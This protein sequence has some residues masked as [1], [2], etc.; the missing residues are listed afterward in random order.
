[1]EDPA[2]AIQ[3]GST[4]LRPG[5]QHAKRDERARQLLLRRYARWE[6]SR[7]LEQLVISYRPLARALAR[8][9]ATAA[10]ARE[11]L[12]QVA[13]VGLIKAIKRFDP[14][15]G[16]AFASFAVP[17]ILGELRR[18]VRDTQWPTRVPRSLQERVRAVRL[19]GERLGG[20]LGR[21]PTAAELATALG[22]DEEDVV[23]ALGVPAALNLVPL[24][25]HTVPVAD[26]I[27]ADD[28]GFERVE[29]MAAI[30]HAMPALS[31]AQRTM[32]QLRFGRDLTQR[33]IAE[34]L[35]LSRAEVARGL[36]EAQSR[37]RSL[38]LA[39]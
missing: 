11:D 24:D 13:Y 10:S 33:E 23:E 25:A 18:H 32:L 15:R 16:V 37:L 35:G 28:P 30:E 27:G 1:M 29:C 14:D 3:T 4:M 20:R 22:D 8:R 34:Q 21:V 7:D 26:Q 31:H 9:Y 19:A 6:R 5:S 36:A 17:T 12:E 2:A 39:A 38:A